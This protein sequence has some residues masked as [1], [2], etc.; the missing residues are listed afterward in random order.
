MKKYNALIR[1]SGVILLYTIKSLC[2]R[3][4]LRKDYLNFSYRV[5]ILIMN[6]RTWIFWWNSDPN[7]M[8]C[9]VDNKGCLHPMYC[10]CLCDWHVAGHHV[11]LI[12]QIGYKLPLHLTRELMADCQA[13]LSVVMNHAKKHGR[14]SPL[15][16]NLNTLYCFPN[17][18][19]RL[20]QYRGN[21]SLWLSI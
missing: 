16:I 21:M 2:C 17:Y 20:K 8:S 15:L 4:K 19:W 12:T 10:L 14:R 13:F 6:L 11:L 1:W 3:L 7:E 5:P 9:D 18:C